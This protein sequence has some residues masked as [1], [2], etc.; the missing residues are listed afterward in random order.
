M[1]PN[2]TSGVPG[3]LTLAPSLE[4]SGPR[5][6]QLRYALWLWLPLAFVV[7]T[8]L[9]VGHWVTLP[10]PEPG[11]AQ[12]TAALEGVRDAR[13]E[14]G[15]LAA[16]VLYAQCSCSKKLLDHLTS[17]AHPAGVDEVLLLVGDG[18]EMA[19]RA[20]AHG[21]R[22]VSI[23][24]EELKSRFNLSAA[25]LLVVADPAGHVRYTGGYTTHKQGPA[26]QDVAILASVMSTRQVAELP[27]FGCAVSKQLQALLDPLA[28]KYRRG[29]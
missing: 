13:K 1:Q 14:R 23:K 7:T 18:P 16:H 20:S 4:Q 6:P 5:L 12:L 21:Y 27:V 19:A 28:L 22:V 8:T 29:Q 25:P 11:D 10:R 17:R 3:V 2:K 9:M 24:P 15:W 26:P